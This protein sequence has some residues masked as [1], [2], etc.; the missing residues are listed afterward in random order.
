MLGL[1][2]EVGGGHYLASVLVL[3]LPF[4]LT[5][6]EDRPPVTATMRSFAWNLIQD[7]VLVNGE[8]DEEYVVASVEGGGQ[9]GGSR[10]HF[11][12]RQV[13]RAGRNFQWP[14]KCQILGCGGSATV[15]AHV[16]IKNPEAI[17]VRPRW[18]ESSNSG[19]GFGATLDSQEEDAPI[20]APVFG[21][22]SDPKHSQR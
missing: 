3:P 11:W 8:D 9:E 4:L 2:E 18:W 22:V 17:M 1:S 16:Y 15:G 13:E 5:C 10:K 19:A 12:E 20:L 6:Q 14:S 7:D 21:V